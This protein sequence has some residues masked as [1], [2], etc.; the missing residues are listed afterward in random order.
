MIS[1][2]NSVTVVIELTDVNDEPPVID[3]KNSI[4]LIKNTDVVSPN[5]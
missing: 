4:I 1:D 2:S 5:F 3:Q